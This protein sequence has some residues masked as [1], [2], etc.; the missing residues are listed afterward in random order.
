MCYF[1]FVLYTFYYIFYYIILFGF[2]DV[3][4]CPLNVLLFIKMITF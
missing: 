1:G 2:I 4:F 3:F